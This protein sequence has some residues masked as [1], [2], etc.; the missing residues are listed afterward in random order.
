MMSIIGLYGQPSEEI[1][2]V[3]SPPLIFFSH[4]VMW[5]FYLRVTKHTKRR[6]LL[7]DS[8]LNKFMIDIDIDILYFPLR[9]HRHENTC[10]WSGK[11]NLPPRRSR[12]LTVRPATEFG[13]PILRQRG[14]GKLPPLDHIYTAVTF[15]HLQ[16]L[17]RNF[18]ASCVNKFYIQLSHCQHHVISASFM[19]S[20]EM[21]TP[22]IICCVFVTITASHN[23]SN[24]A[25]HTPDYKT[26]MLVYDLVH[27]IQVGGQ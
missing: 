12:S 23:T 15:E 4:S 20:P 19:T 24:V 1:W 10:S 21:E 9:I 16:I 14:L 3:V 17:A 11:C 2:W 7:H 8:A 6:E 25:S 18:C 22:P 13:W 5:S 26:I 27:N